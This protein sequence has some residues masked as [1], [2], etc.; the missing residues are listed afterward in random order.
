M[1]I[2][3]LLCCCVLA[4]IQFQGVQNELLS[5]RMHPAHWTG[6]VFQ[7]L[8]NDNFARCTVDFSLVKI[9]I[10]LHRSQVRSVRCSC[11]DFAWTCRQ[12][13]QS[14]PI[15]WWARSWY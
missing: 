11:P 7:T 5:N 4:V 3:T 6:I 12:H 9:I 10:L 13:Q 1:S 8:Q 15:W 14:V 2:T